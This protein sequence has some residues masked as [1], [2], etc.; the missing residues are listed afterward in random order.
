MKHNH[1]LDEEYRAAW[2]NYALSSRELQ[3]AADCEDRGRVEPLLLSV[4]TARL[5]YSV[6]RDRL[7]AR[8]AGAN[9]AV[10]TRLRF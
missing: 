7:A 6:A 9:S 3:H 10:L 5:K 2:E 4:E 8:M 1:E